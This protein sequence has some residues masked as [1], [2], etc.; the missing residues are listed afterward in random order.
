VKEGLFDMTALA[1]SGVS[2]ASAAGAAA[3]NRSKV[4]EMTQAA[5]DAVLASAQPGAWSANLRAALAT[6]I[7][8]HN[9]EIALAE[10]YAAKTGDDPVSALADPSEDGVAQGM[11]AVVAFMDKV[12]ARTS[13]VTAHDIEVLKSAGIADAD[14]VRL[15]ELNAFLAYQI[16][17]VAGLRLMGGAP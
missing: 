12:A 2:E 6:R 17:L 9:G 14:I 5:E 8:R 1:V 3:M 13:E 11:G 16:R 15:A 10:R 4:M 7:A